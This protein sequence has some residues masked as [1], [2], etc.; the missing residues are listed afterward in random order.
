V[1]KCR[2][3]SC[4][5]THEDQVTF[6]LCTARTCSSALRISTTLMLLLLMC[7]CTLAFGAAATARRSL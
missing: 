4:M 6:V 2:L 5:H 7:S 1:T 3:N